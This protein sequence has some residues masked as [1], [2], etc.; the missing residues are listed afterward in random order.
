MARH[1]RLIPK[2]L[3]SLKGTVLA[4]LSLGNIERPLALARVMAAV[5]SNP[6][7]IAYLVTTAGH[8]HKKKTM[9]A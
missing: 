4:L 6:G 7:K 9:P 5:G 3:N 2:T 1:W 8:G